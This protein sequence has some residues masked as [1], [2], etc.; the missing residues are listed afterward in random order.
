LK[1]A[2]DYNRTTLSPLGTRVL[3]HEKP[4]V[5]GTWTTHG[6]VDGCCLSP[7]M[8]RYRCY[9]V[10]IAKITA[11]R[12]TDAVVWFLS[13]VTMPTASS[14]DA[15]TTAARD[16][17]HALLNPSLHP[18]LSHKRQ[19]TCDS[20]HRALH[21]ILLQ[22]DNRK[23]RNTNPIADR[24]TRVTFAPTTPDPALPRVAPSAPTTRQE[25]LPLQ[26]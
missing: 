26:V 20:Q 9:R 17:I 15:A 5:R 1:R 23:P 6:A 7:A 3:A 12:I 11:E 21:K 14:A 18:L 13:I 24:R 22:S 2:I 19:P 16:L 8:N 10:W 25:N 4:T